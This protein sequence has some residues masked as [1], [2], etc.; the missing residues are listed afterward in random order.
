MKRFADLKFQHGSRERQDQIDSSLQG[1]IQNQLNQAKMILKLG[2]DVQHLITQRNAP[3]Y[4]VYE[5][6]PL[7]SLRAAF[8]ELPGPEPRTRGEIEGVDRSGLLLDEAPD[9]ADSGHLSKE[10][11]RSRRLY[12]SE[13][14]LQLLDPILKRHGRNIQNIVKITSNSLS[15][16]IAN[17]VKSRLRSWMKSSR[18][19]AI[20]IQGPH[21]VSHP[22]QNTLTAVC[23]A[24]LA[25]ETQELEDR[26][27]VRH[28]RNLLRTLRAIAQPSVSSEAGSSVIPGP[29]RRGAEATDVPVP[30]EEQT[31]RVTKVCLTSD[32]NVDVLARL[33]EYAYLSKVEYADEADQDTAGSLT[34]D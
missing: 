14:M 17:E 22:S 21:E 3:R 24:A 16:V 30:E 15:V 34:L 23:L 13:E 33:V 20:W 25:N 4:D 26:G 19:E 10:D 9:R 6:T 18:H 29:S 27:D 7:L 32:G 2:E 1:I 31:A 11:E 8:G 12:D 5:G 28:T